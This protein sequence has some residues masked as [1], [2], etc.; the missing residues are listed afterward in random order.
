MENAKEFSI[1]HVAEEGD[2]TVQEMIS[3]EIPLTIILND[4]ELVTLLC[5]PKNMDYLVYGFLFAEGLVKSKN[6]IK[7]TIVDKKRGVARVTLRDNIDADRDL[8]FKRL[9]TSACGRGAAFYSAIDAQHPAKVES[10]IQ[11]SPREV[12]NLVQAFIQHSKVYQITHGVHSAA[13]TDNNKIIVFNDDLGRHN[14]IDKVFGECL[15]KEIPTEGRIVI[16][17]GRTPSEMILKVAKGKVPILISIA[18]PTDLGIRL[19]NDLGVTL[20]GNV[21][22]PAMNIYT[23]GWRVVDH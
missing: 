21:R 20:I 6:D 7:E 9:I 4:L 10:G 13:L 12:S 14:A 15:L 23:H 5:S 16:T 18:A 19:A 17:T 1:L 22:G 11:I 3:R 8:L 2:S